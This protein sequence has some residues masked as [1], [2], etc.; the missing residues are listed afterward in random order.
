MK[1]TTTYHEKKY[2]EDTLKVR[3]LLSTLPAFAKEY[4][5]AIEPTT[6]VRTRIAYAYDIRVFFTFLLDSNPSYKN[7][8][9]EDFRPS[10]LDLVQSVD[11]EEY[12]EYLKVYD[13]PDKQMT[14]TERGIYRK[15]SSLRSFYA[16]FYKR[17]IIHTNPT[18]LID[19]PKIHEKN[20]IRLE[21]DEIA[22][23]LD[24]IEQGGEGLTGQRKAYYE[25][26]KIRDFAIVTLLLGT[27][28]RV[29]ELV[30][31]DLSDVDFKNNGLHLIRKGDKEMIVYFGDE[32]EYALRQY[33]DTE[34]KNI[35]PLPGHEHALFYSI[36]KKRIGVQAVQN[37]VKKYA[38]EITP[39]KKITP[40]KLRS[41]Y[42]TSLYQETDDIYLVAEV[43]GHS[44]VNTTR[45]HY[46][47][48]SDQKRRYAA[49]KVILREKH[50]QS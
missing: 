32:V 50:S 43:L 1:D 19:M 20:I 27:G 17:Q 23:L 15:M 5:R 8:K 48:M 16:Y 33:I 42:G 36:Q 14:N 9:I 22:S 4:F 34:R 25:K 47:A 18:L 7:R 28:I 37:L 24:Y 2:V 31:L 12:M 30:G 21:P 35:I 39:L 38:K 26:T 3:E 10:D 45:K 49:N 11:L 13:A 29:S 41:T 6:S 46:A 40:H 44:D